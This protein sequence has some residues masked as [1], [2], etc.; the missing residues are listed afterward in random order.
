MNTVGMVRT[1]DNLGRITMPKEFRNILGFKEGRL[2]EILEEKNGEIILKKCTEETKGVVRKLDQL[3][4]FVIPKKTRKRFGIKNGDNIEMLAREDGNIIVKKYLNVDFQ[5]SAYNEHVAQIRQYAD[6]LAGLTNF[7][8]CIT[9]KNE[10]IAI[11]GEENK[12]YLGGMVSKKVLCMAE[13]GGI[14]Y[15]SCQFL[16]ILQDEDVS[17]YKLQIIVPIIKYQKTIGT[18]ILFSCDCNKSTNIYGIARMAA[19]DLSNKM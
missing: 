6:F 9:D 11:S 14:L 13:K 2:I 18:I 12:Y 10:V 1:L 16:P 4:R 19:E 5:K 17:K 8:T 7:V 15:T 3:G